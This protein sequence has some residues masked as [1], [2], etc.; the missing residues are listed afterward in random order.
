MN[1][2]LRRRTLA[3]AGAVLMLCAHPLAEAVDKPEDSRMWMT[4]G[5]RRFAVT[6]ANTPA[7]KAF[8]AQL[9][10]TLDMPD[11]NA[12]EKHVKLPRALPSNPSRPGTIRSG[13]IMLW[14]SDTLVVFYVTF[15]SQYSYTRIGR[16]D[17]G[18]VLKEAFGPGEVRITFSRK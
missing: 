7:A 11:L 5:D 13:D 15:E 2:M 17:D 1:G 14:G 3:A 18:A 16:V 9:P 12:N 6:L 10:L 4:V 8:A